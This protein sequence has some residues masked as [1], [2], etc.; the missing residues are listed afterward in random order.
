MLKAA[1]LGSPPCSPCSQERPPHWASPPCSLCSQEHAVGCSMRHASLQPHASLIDPPSIGPGLG[2]ITTYHV[3]IIFGRITRLLFAT[4]G[5]HYFAPDL[6]SAQ[7]QKV[8]IL[9][10][11][12]LEVVFFIF[13]YY[14]FFYGFGLM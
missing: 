3:H 13:Y 9:L 12:P 8:K 7:R 11:S 5:S 10:V 14:Y 4:H 2:P 6:P 1:P